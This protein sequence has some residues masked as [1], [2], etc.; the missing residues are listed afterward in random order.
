MAFS[1]LVYQEIITNRI[2]DSIQLFET[3]S[4]HILH[5][6]KQKHKSYSDIMLDQIVY[7]QNLFAQH[8]CLQIHQSYPS[9]RFYN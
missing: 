9:S 5:S 6:F 1:F 2:Y 8:F 7:H 4:E 3:T